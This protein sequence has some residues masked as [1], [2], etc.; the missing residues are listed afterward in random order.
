MIRTVRALPLLLLLPALLTG[1]GTEKADA[2]AGGGSSSAT[3][4]ASELN[5]RVRALGVA[6]ELVYVT[7][8]SGFTP[9]QQS[10]GVNGDDG[11]SVSYWS[12]SG[13]VLHLYSDRGTVT[14]AVC[15]EEEECVA[16]KK[17]QVVHI[18]GEKVSREVLREAARAVHRPS[19][20]ELAAIL[21][22]PAATPTEPVRRGDLPS[23]GDGAPD[24]SVGEGG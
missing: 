13:G 22:S 8:A 11:F 24:N 23:Y 7:G 12:K 3:P 1:C 20:E 10:V 14:P 4:D 19:A 5:S 2:G 21:P 6:P 9:A 17:G 15:P 16:P 18:S